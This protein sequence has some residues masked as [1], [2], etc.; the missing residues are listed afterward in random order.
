MR[1]VWYTYAASRCEDLECKLAVYLASTSMPSVK[2]SR[3]RVC[4]G[5]SGSSVVLTFVL[6][7]S[8]AFV[9]NRYTVIVGST[10][11][12]DAQP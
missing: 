1:Y 11:E 12:R 5:A 7:P 3:T 10:D 9:G 8:G 2:S 4:I 6:R